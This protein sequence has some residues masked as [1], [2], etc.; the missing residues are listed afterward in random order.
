MRSEQEIYALIEKVAQGD[1]NIRAVL[2][3]GSRANEKIKPDQYQDYDLVFLVTSLHPFSENPDWIN[4][5]G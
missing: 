5:F 2:L 1:P 4:V 3:N